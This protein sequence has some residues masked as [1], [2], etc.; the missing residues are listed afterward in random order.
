MSMKTKASTPAGGAA[1]WEGV[2]QFNGDLSPTAARALLK[3][4]FSPHDRARMD[5]LSQKARAGTL[6]STEQADLDTFERLGCL[7]DIV[8]SKARRVLKKKPKRAS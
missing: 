2:I 1:I 7:L 6:T 3:F 4:G 8:H 5:D